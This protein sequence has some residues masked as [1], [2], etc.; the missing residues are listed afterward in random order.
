MQNR[1]HIRR[2]A[3]EDASAIATMVGALLR[4]I[5]DG[6]GYQAFHF[7]RNETISQLKRF[8]KEEQYIVFIAIDSKEI[9]RGFISLYESCSLY[10]GGTFGTIPEFY[11]DPDYRS[12]GVGSLLASEAKRFAAR[13]GWTRLEVTTPPLPQFERSLSFYQK[14]GF[15]ITGGRKLKIEIENS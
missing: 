4:E 7:D 10:A 12:Q 13:Q 11:T 15:T 9:P 6:I 14:E 3:I 1:V 5:M 8:L 2:A